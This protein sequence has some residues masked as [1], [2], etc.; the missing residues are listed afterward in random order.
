MDHTDKR[1][2]RIE[3][4]MLTDVASRSI[5]IMMAPDI[6]IKDLA[7]LVAATVGF[8]GKIA[9]D[10]SK[11]D[12]TPRKLMAVDHLRDLGWAPRIGLQNGLRS[13]YEWF[14]SHVNDFR[15]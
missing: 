13:T 12:G 3:H 9:R 6:A 8:E 1:I 10:L 2:I 7:R 14:L 5:D 11:P 4:D 15:R